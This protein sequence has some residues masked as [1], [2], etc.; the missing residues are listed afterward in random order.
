L[1]IQIKDRKDKRFKLKDDKD[2]KVEDKKK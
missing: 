1:K 2:K